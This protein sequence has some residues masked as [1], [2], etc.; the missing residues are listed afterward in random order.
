MDSEKLSAEEINMID[1]MI[2]DDF[3]KGVEKL[4][5]VEKKIRKLLRHH[6][7]RKIMLR[8]KISDSEKN[9][10]KETNPKQKQ[11]GNN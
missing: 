3:R 9:F 7:I 6:L 1:D 2:D 4:E 11:G 5:K 8:K 10:D